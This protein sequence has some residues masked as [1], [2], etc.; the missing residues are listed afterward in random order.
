MDF[1]TLAST[2]AGLA[3]TIKEHYKELRSSAKR[4][5]RLNGRID[6]LEVTVTEMTQH[7][8]KE[9]PKRIKGALEGVHAE[10]KGVDD[11]FKDLKTHGILRRLFEAPSTNDKYRDIEANLDYAVN[12][13]DLAQNWQHSRQNE[14]FQR[15]ALQLMETMHDKVDLILE[16]L[17]RLNDRGEQQV[18]SIEGDLRYNQEMM[19]FLQAQLQMID[20]EL[21]SPRY[22]E[23]L[24]Q[25]QGGKLEEGNEGQGR[26]AKWQESTK[27]LAH[28][29]KL[30][31]LL[32]SRHRQPLNLT[33]FYKVYEARDAI[34]V[35]C[36][37]LHAFV[38]DWGFSSVKIETV[39]P[40]DRVRR[41]KSRLVGYLT[42]ALYEGEECAFKNEHHKEEWKALRA[43]VKG[44][45]DLLPMVVQKGDLQLGE[46]IDSMVYKGTWEGS[47]VAV[48]RLARGDDPATLDLEDFAE[49]FT[50]IVALAKISSNHV[51][52]FIGATEA[53]MVLMELGH[54][55][56]FRW[57]DSHHSATLAT[58]LG[59]LLQAA[60][61]LRD[62][63][64]KRFVHRA[65]RTRKFVIF[66]DKATPT[67]K[68]AGFGLAIVRHEGEASETFRT[69]I[70]KDRD[71]AWVAPEIFTG[72][73][74]TTASDIYSFGI[75]LYHV[76]GGLYPYG[77]STP[78]AEVMRRVRNGELPSLPNG[79]QLPERL[80]TL[81]QKC[82][83]TEPTQ[84]PVSMQQVCD[85]L[86]A[87]HDNLKN[88]P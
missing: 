45:F 3:L 62:V 71:T 59:M 54:T 27:N 20:I 14:E 28:A 42:Y 36:E 84:R 70:N 29:R 5:E 73:A 83:S 76:L 11:L 15:Q 23:L 6:T 39:V 47:P 33:T 80:S 10:L 31:Y 50:T 66:G 72:K 55:D 1:F 49:F 13:L 77:R 88:C 16:K 86:E 56:L 19:E 74:Y 22:Q 32:I 65:V 64:K 85:D 17:S 61:G 63:H 35:I 51:V 41:D 8:E 67:V 24:M 48:K 79:M 82:C 43:R 2:I 69:Y 25:M 44:W 26:R 46:C 57:L 9:P 81:M 60:K 34:Q 52:D 37:M 87:V 12:V 18:D 75:V 58:K 40:S 7:Y 53:G 4:K 30:G 78:T 21:S 68:I 38:K